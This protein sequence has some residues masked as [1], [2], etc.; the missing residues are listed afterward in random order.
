[1]FVHNPES[2]TFNNFTHLHH[3]LQLIESQLLSISDETVLLDL[4]HLLLEAKQSVPAFL[5]TMMGDDEKY[6]DIGGK[7]HFSVLTEFVPLLEGH[8]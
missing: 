1:M 5:A 4:K 7:I 3:F 8:I 2:G 6:L